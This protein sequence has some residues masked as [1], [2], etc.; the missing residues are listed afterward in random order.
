MLSRL[1]A[2]LK[3]SVRRRNNKKTLQRT[4]AQTR[5]ISTMVYCYWH[6]MHYLLQTR[7]GHHLSMRP[8]PPPPEP[9]YEV[10]GEYG[11]KMGNTNSATTARS[12]VGFAGQIITKFRMHDL[13]NIIFGRFSKNLLASYFLIKYSKKVC[14]IF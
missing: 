1:L 9:E 12:P 7:V 4:R 6:S 5:E 2:S 10:I 13:L 11:R 14:F 3:L 8:L